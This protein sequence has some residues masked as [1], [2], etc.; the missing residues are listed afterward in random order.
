MVFGGEGGIKAERVCRL[1]HTCSPFEEGILHLWMG[2][3]GCPPVGM[4]VG[5]AGSQRRRGFFW[6]GGGTRRAK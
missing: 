5:W 3:V 4:G 1:V 6:G 2:W